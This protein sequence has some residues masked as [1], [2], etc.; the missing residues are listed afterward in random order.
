[1]IFNCVRIVY[2]LGCIAFTNVFRFCYQWA[3]L[4]YPHATKFC[5]K[6]INPYNFSNALLFD[7][8]SFNQLYEFSVSLSEGSPKQI[9]LLRA[10]MCVW[11]LIYC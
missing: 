5:D 9:L 4:F 11:F 10:V 6:Q 7:L 8:S 1:M 2:Y 3:M